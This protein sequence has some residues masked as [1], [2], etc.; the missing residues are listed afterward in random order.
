MI[1]THCHI[2]DLTLYDRR[3]EIVKNAL[4]SGVEKII[5]IGWDLESSKLAVSI[6][7]EYDC[8]FAAV[9]FHPEN[10]ETISDEALAEIE[11][12]TLN[13]K[14][15]A[16]GEIGL[17]YHWFKEQKDRDTQKVWFIKQI[18]LAN[19]LGLPISIHAREATQDT[20]EILKEFPPQ[21]GCVLHCYSGSKEMMDRFDKIGV[22]YGF[23]GPIT[24]KN[25]INPRECVEKCNINKIVVETDSPYM[26]PVP[27]RG[28]ENEPKYIPDIISK[29]AEIKGITI[30][31]AD[32]IT[33]RNA[34]ELFGF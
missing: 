14:V 8:V 11:Q 33:T 28:K 18:K 9:G 5:C 31:E 29:M 24:F 19:K 21:K 15:V 23:D 17:D 32:R 2:N 12:L 16:I 10:L 27:H 34:Y 1:D 25:A 7:Q 4:A 22:Y 20:Y 6:A 3:D 30:E 26:A 13:K